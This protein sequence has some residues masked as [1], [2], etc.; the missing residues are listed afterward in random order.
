M[1]ASRLD[2]EHRGPRSDR[3][4]IAI[5]VLLM[6]PILIG[7]AGVAYDAGNML[8]AKREARSVAASAARAGAQA[9]DEESIYNVD[10][11]RRLQLNE[12]L[13]VERATEMADLL[14][15]FNVV[16]EMPSDDQIRVE[17][18]NVVAPLFLDFFG[19][20]SAEMRGS[21]TARTRSA[22]T[23]DDDDVGD[24]LDN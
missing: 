4:G 2:Q 3:G 12:A 1:S 23:E 18:G 17:V 19:I 5:W 22:V 10:G 6:I 8:A 24:F 7:L 11:S 14:G 15:G 13:A 9:I 21:F 20:G 16:V